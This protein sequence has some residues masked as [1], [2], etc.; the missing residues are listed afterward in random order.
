MCNHV[1]PFVRFSVPLTLP[2]RELVWLF[3]EYLGVGVPARASTAHQHTN[4]LFAHMSD[5]SPLFQPLRA[6]IRAVSGSMH[7]EEAFVD[8]SAHVR[9]ALSPEIWGADPREGFTLKMD[10]L[11]APPAPSYETGM[12]HVVRGLFSTFFSS[13]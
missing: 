12:L 9:E 4:T 3:L 11:S 10:C 7:S 5:A 8:P 13:H 2:Q 6:A 1:P